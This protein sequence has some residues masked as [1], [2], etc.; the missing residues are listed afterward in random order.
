MKLYT[1]NRAVVILAI[2]KR[3]IESLKSEIDCIYPSW[4]LDPHIVQ[5]IRIANE[6][7]MIWIKSAALYD[8]YKTEETEKE[9]IE[10]EEKWKQCRKEC[11]D[12]ANLWVNS[13]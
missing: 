5:M 9:M 3:H 12:L 10:K 1:L 8:K 2:K 13:S 6:V 4:R 11:I 7:C